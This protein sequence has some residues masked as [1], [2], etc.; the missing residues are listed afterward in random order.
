MSRKSESE[1]EKE[2]DGTVAVQEGVSTLFPLRPWIFSAMGKLWEF[3][4]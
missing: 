2:E 4:G 1:V 3:L